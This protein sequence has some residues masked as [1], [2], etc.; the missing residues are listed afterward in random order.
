MIPEDILSRIAYLSAPQVDFKQA[1]SLGK[2][3][4]DFRPN[5]VKSNDGILETNWHIDC[6][7]EEANNTFEN[8][9]LP[10][11]FDSFNVATNDLRQFH[12]T[13]GDCEYMEGYR[14][15]TDFWIGERGSR[16]FSIMRVELDYVGVFDHRDTLPRLPAFA[17][18]TV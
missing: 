3:I 13:G 18:R 8:F 4:D 6:R 10:V 1:K 16:R 17:V 7:F 14:G 12:G 5:N 11:L 15:E 2:I 9:V